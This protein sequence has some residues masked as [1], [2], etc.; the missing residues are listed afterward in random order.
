MLHPDEPRVLE[1]VRLKGD[2]GPEIPPFESMEEDYYRKNYT[3]LRAGWTAGAVL[4]TL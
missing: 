1:S 3:A 2:V 4:A